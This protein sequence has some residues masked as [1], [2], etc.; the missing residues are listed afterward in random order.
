MAKEM[1][2]PAL[3]AELDDDTPATES[4]LGG[5]ITLTLKSSGRPWGGT[6]ITAAAQS[7]GFDWDRGEV[8]SGLSLFDSFTG[9]CFARIDSMQLGGFKPATGQATTVEVTMDPA[10]IEGSE[11]I[12]ASSMGA[13]ERFH[14]AVSAMAA[15]LSADI[16][17]GAGVPISPEGWLRI[18]Q[19]VERA[20]AA[21]DEAR[22]LREGA[23]DDGRVPIE[24]LF[25]RVKRSASNWWA[26]LSEMRMQK[27]LP[28]WVLVKHPGAGTN[29]AMEQY[30][31]N[32]EALTTVLIDGG[33]LPRARYQLG[34][35]L[36]DG[37]QTLLDTMTGE[38]VFRGSAIDLAAMHVCALE[39]L[40]PRQLTSL[41]NAIRREAQSVVLRKADDPD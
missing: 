29:E 19:D 33:Q 8:R 41:A 20:L 34:E 2:M 16:V 27:Q 26:L 31:G 35:F 38:E 1:D 24:T 18:R 23:G 25:N 32:W 21:A 12:P 22:E 15:T 37:Q 3:M 17:D 11:W 5:S 40:S 28:E 6:E 7:V 10:E 4:A 9:N 14:F 30:R 13:M 39:E 36:D